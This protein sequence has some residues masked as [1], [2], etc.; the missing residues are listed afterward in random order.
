[1]KFKVLFVF[2]L[3]WFL[4]LK[5][6]KQLAHQLLVPVIVMHNEQSFPAFVNLQIVLNPRFLGL[7]IIE[8]F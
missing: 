6:S 8:P 4:T 2:V 1:L 3:E 5:A 7:L